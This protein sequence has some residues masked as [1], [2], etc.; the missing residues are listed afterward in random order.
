MTNETRPLHLANARLIEPVT[1]LVSPGGVLVEAGRI[2]DIA[3]ELASARVEGAERL[4]CAGAIV[5]PG[6]VDLRAFIGEPG[7][8]FRETLRSASEAAVA[9]GVTTLIAQ[10]NTSPVIDDPAVVDFVLRRARDTS[11]VHI[12]PAAAL[13]KGCRGQEMT[14]IGLLKA[15]G[16]V[17]VTDG[18][19]PVVNAQVMRRC[20]A[21]ARMFD[22]PVIHHPED[23]HLVGEGVMN[24]G[25]FATRLGLPGIPAA[26]EAIMLE[27]DMRLVHLTGA[28]Y[29]AA[30]VS[31]RESLDILRRAKQ[32]GLPVTAGVSINHLTLNELDIGEYRTFLKLSPPL[33]GEEDRL[34]LVE[35]VAEGLIDVI[36]SDH[37]PQDVETKRLTFAECAPG[38]I[39]LETMLA[40]GMRLVEAGLISLPRLIEA[41]SAA[42]ARLAGLDTGRLARGAPADLIVF[43]PEEPWLVDPARLRSLC[44]NTPFDGARMSGR[45]TATLVAGRI[46]HQYR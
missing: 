34:A 46:V 14:E 13:T 10:P 29:H 1:G 30:L 19:R 12:R 16:A 3:P 36:V 40:A 37:N 41:M 23:P 9:G 32:A 38:A 21:Y 6:L 43:D 7:E 42:P 33:R 17:A 11:L 28:R 45:V 26:A 8:E 31:C 25:E 44:K 5:A 20:L 22:M 27:R 35:A 18:D 4:D 24:E 2:R 39:G 15:A